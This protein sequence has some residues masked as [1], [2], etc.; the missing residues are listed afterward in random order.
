MSDEPKL[1][2]LQVNTTG[3]WRN[4]MQ[5]DVR[6]DSAVMYAAPLLFSLGTDEGMRTKLRVIIPGD[7]APLVDWCFEKGWQEWG[8][9][10]AARGVRGYA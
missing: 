8:K 6:G 5:F 1:V 3:G 7:T 4:V 2:M 9:K 10:M